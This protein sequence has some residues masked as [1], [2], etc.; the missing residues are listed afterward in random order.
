MTDPAVEAE[1]TEKIRADAARDLTNE[2]KKLMDGGMSVSDA[3]AKMRNEIN[4]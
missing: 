1:K 4:A 3:F 2:L